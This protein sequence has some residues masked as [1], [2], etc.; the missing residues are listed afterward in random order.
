MF[1]CEHIRTNEL[2]LDKLYMFFLL[3]GLLKQRTFVFYMIY[4]I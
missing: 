3:Y 4:I 1:A 2:G